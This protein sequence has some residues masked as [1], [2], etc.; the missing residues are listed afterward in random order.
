MS[1]VAQHEFEGALENVPHW[2]PV[3]AGGFHGHVGAGMV[4]NQSDS[5]SNPFVVLQ[6]L[7]TS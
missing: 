2:F 7:C 1:G 6:K 5:A 3:N 4:T